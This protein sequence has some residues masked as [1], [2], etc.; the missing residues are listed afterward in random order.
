MANRIQKEI[1]GAANALDCS[2]ETTHETIIILYDTGDC[3]AAIYSNS[4]DV[5]TQGILARVLSQQGLF[6]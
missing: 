6:A 4:A 1:M 3:I 2:G 5:S